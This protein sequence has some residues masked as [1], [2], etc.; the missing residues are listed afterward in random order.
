MKAKRRG[1]APVILT[2]VV[3]GALPRTAWPVSRV[4]NNRI[5]DPAMGFETAVPAGWAFQR[6]TSDGGVVLASFLV[7]PGAGAGVGAGPGFGAGYLFVRPSLVDYP[8]LASASR[9]E[10]SAF[11]EEAADASWTPISV[12]DCSLRYVLDDGTTVVGVALW[13]GG[14]GITIVAPSSRNALA[15]TRS[16]ITNLQLAQASCPWP[17]P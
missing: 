4:G 7:P 2:L 6:S 13:G 12:S 1:L 10:A 5:G 11:F 14:R 15:A 3:T 8:D 9:R 17:A 16:L